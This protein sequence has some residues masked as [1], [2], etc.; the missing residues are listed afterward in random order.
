LTL[1]FITKFQI[2][3]LRLTKVENG[4]DLKYDLSKPKVCNLHFPILPRQNMEE[5]VGALMGPLFRLTYLL[6]K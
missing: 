3:K 1:L 4:R 2:R 6:S 5:P